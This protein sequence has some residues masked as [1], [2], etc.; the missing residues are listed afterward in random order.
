M[1]CD[2]EALINIEGAV[3]TPPVMLFRDDIMLVKE[4]G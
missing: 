1:R 2:T 3:H 4:V